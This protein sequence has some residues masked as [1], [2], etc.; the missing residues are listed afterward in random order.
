MPPPPLYL[1]ETKESVIPQISL[2]TL[3]SKFNGVTEK[4]CKTHRDS[5]IRVFE[6]MKLPSYLILYMR[7]FVKNIFTLEK[8]PTIV[9]FP[10]KSIDFGELL[11][12]E[13]RKKHRFV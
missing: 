13:F 7:R 10:I 9:N 3:L 12:L 1:D 6:L 5:T 11:A 2:A 8:N 4:E